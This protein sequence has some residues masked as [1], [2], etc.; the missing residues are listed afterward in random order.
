MFWQPGDCYDDILIERDGVQIATIP[1]L[2]S[3]Y[4][5]FDAEAG[6]RSYTVTGR[7]AGLAD[8]GVTCEV[9]VP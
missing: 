9:T 1:E 4:L 3:A 7:K 5:D 8:T 6:V 2:S